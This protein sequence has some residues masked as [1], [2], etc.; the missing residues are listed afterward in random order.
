M[1]T[2]FLRHLSLCTIIEQRIDSTAHIYI[3]RSLTS[4][5]RDIFKQVSNPSSNLCLTH[6]AISYDIKSSN[7]LGEPR[8]Y[9]HLPNSP[10]DLT[11]TKA[12]LQL[13]SHINS[14][15]L[16]ISNCTD[17]YLFS[18]ASTTQVTQQ[19]TQ[20]PQTGPCK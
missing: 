6:L 11:P 1:A 9:N 12:L 4:L 8:K 20:T 7:A 15:T 3:I 19:C 14:Q 16:Y 17:I 10:Y 2:P 5:K 18:T 13:S